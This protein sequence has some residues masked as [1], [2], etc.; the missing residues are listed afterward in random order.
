METFSS[1]LNY[2]YS[3]AYSKDPSISI[4]IKVMFITNW[5]FIK[6]NDFEKL[7]TRIDL[8]N[9]KPSVNLATCFNYH[10]IASRVKNAKCVYDTSSDTKWIIFIP[11]PNILE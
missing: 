3:I 6:G 8:I 10:M 11:T 9:G 2:F 5:A 1:A 4:P 7:N